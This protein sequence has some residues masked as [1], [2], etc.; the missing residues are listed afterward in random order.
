MREVTEPHPPL[1][2][3]LVATLCFLHLPPLGAAVVVE[4]VQ[5]AQVCLAA[6]VA[7]VAIQVPLVVQEIHLP[8]LH[9]KVTT[10]VAQTLMGLLIPM[11]AEVAELTQLV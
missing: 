10:A 6:P 8:L 5:M 4:L 3:H 11:V 1:E 7:V 2:A 9:L